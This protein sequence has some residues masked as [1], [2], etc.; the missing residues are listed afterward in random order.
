MKVISFSSLRMMEKRSMWKLSYITKPPNVKFLFKIIERSPMSDVLICWKRRNKG[1][2]EVGGIHLCTNKAFKMFW[3]LLNPGRNVETDSNQPNKVWQIHLHQYGASC[4]ENQEAAIHA[5]TNQHGR[6]LPGGKPA[7]YWCIKQ[8]EQTD[9]LLPVAC[10]LEFVFIYRRQLTQNLR[11]FDEKKVT[12]VR[13]WTEA[14]ALIR[15]SPQVSVVAAT[16]EETLISDCHWTTLSVVAMVSIPF[17][18]TLNL[19]KTNRCSQSR[20]P[21]EFYLRSACPSLV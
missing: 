1:G 2:G 21:L 20:T 11:P 18:L 6:R 3:H 12:T 8:A 9:E 14:L 4:H 5:G 10:I 19:Q 15:W 13:R 17:A 16:W 7:E